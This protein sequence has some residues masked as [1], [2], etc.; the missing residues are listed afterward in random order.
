MTAMVKNLFLLV[1]KNALIIKDDFSGDG[2]RLK[3]I[4]ESKVATLLC[5]LKTTTEYLRFKWIRI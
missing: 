1:L 4:T 5:G 2:C 3:T